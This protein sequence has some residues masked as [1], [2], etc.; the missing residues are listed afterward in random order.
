V[1]FS[2]TGLAPGPLRLALVA[3]GH[4]VFDVVS[5]SLAGL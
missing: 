2:W 1:L 3:E 4:A 5:I